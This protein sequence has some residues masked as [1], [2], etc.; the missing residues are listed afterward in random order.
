MTS[1]D[2]AAANEELGMEGFG[3]EG[4]GFR[5]ESGSRAGGVAPK[6]EVEVKG[7]LAKVTESLSAA[8]PSTS[9]AWVELADWQPVASRAHSA[10]APAA[11][12]E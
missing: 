2:A 9:G 5:P 7:S 8:A 3:L 4:F 11:G 10:I 6:L 1:G 12:R